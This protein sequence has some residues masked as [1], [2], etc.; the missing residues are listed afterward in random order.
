M[1]SHVRL[2]IT[3]PGDTDDDSADINNIKHLLR[4]CCLFSSKLINPMKAHF[5]FT[6]LRRRRL[7]LAGV[8]SVALTWTLHVKPRRNWESMISVSVNTLHLW[9]KW[10]WIMA[11]K[12]TDPR[13]KLRSRPL[14][15]QLGDFSQ[16]T[17]SLCAS[18]FFYLQ[19]GK[20]TITSQML[21]I[22]MSVLLFAL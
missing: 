5:S 10:H 17:Q 8:K 11:A 6:L 7:R 22:N 4:T 13:A 14:S 2:I 3:V 20:N 18:G 15:E 21:T 19:S 9:L 16:F 1:G 12:N